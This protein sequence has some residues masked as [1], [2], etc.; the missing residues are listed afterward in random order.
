MFDLDKWQEIFETIQ[1]NK[2]R[3]LATAFGVF[4]GILMLVMLLGAGQGLQNGVKHSMLLDATN[5]IWFFT[6]KTSIPYKGFP[7]GRYLEFNEEDLQ[8]IEDNIEGIDV[9]S[10]ENV[11]FGNFTTSYQ[12]KST[13]VGVFGAEEDYF[14]VKVTMKFV[15]GRRL[16]IQDDIAGRKVCIIGSV[17]RDALFEPKE[18]PI[19]AYINVKGVFFK[20][21]GVYEF[22]GYGRDQAERVHIPFS[23]FQRTF[24][25]DKSVSLFTVT[26]QAGVSGKGLE[27]RILRLLAQRHNVHPDD[28]QAFWTHNQED[29]HR[30]I[31]MLFLG[32]KTFIW[33]VGVLTLVAGIVGVSNIMI[34]VVKERTKEIGI[35]KAVGATPWSIVSLILQESILITTVAGYFGLVIAVLLLETLPD[36]LDAP[37]RINSKLFSAAST[38][39]LLRLK[40]NTNWLYSKSEITFSWYSS[41]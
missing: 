31:L 7:P 18:D 4:W 14:D 13:R 3:T 25:P 38:R 2:L 20:C 27:E 28:N 16:N 15:Q 5:S 24:N 26:T 34:I 8:T 23:T 22:Q 9:M 6:W 32:I 29:E 19:G 11:M 40:A 12:G 41:F 35:R 37:S 21:V 33:T 36:F 39:C 17:V 30:S 1:K 10:P